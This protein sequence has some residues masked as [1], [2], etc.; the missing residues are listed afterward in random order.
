MLRILQL[1]LNEG[2]SDSVGVTQGAFTSL[3]LQNVGQMGAP[4]RVDPPAVSQF[5]SSLPTATKD[6]PCQLLGFIC[7]AVTICYDTS[8]AVARGDDVAAYTASLVVLNGE[9]V[10]WEASIPQ[11]W[12]YSI[13]PKSA[14][15]LDQEQDFPPAIL[16]FP[17]INTMFLWV[18]FW[19]IRMDV[20]QCLH[21]IY[22]HTPQ[23]PAVRFEMSLL[24]DRICAAVPHMT[25]Q[26]DESTRAGPHDPVKNLASLFAMRSLFVASQV[27]DLPAVKKTWML[28]QLEFI[29]QRRGIGQALG[30]RQ[31]LQRF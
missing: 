26:T 10:S 19:M 5:P 12:R 7:Q 11:V 1:R 25:G 24:V 27:L 28:Q 20:L 17:V 16:T 29:G 3:M 13:I 2:S 6:L 18:S 22:T 8:V 15:V 23:S 14:T 9:L 21:K 30:L 31:F 4:P